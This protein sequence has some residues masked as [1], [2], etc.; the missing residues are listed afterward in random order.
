MMA[1]GVFVMENTL[2]CRANVAWPLTT[3]GSVGCASAGPKQA[4][5]SRARQLRRN[6]GWR[7][8]AGRRAATLAGWVFIGWS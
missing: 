1:F 8:G 4:P 6:G 7:D 2:P 3:C 5:I